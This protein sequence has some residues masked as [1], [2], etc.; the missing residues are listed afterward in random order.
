[1]ELSNLDYI[2]ENRQPL[3]LSRRR[4]TR[5]TS[6]DGHRHQAGAAFEAC[7]VAESV[8]QCDVVAVRLQLQSKVKFIEKD[9]YNNKTG[10]LKVM[11]AL[12]AKPEGKAEP[13]EW[14]ELEVVEKFDKFQVTLK[15]MALIKDKVAEY[16]VENL[17]ENAEADTTTIDS[18]AEQKK[19]L[20]K[21]LSTLRAVRDHDRSAA[22]NEKRKQ[23][24][25]TTKLIL[26][27]QKSELPSELSDWF[28]KVLLDG[29]TP[30][31][32]S[33][34]K[35]TDSDCFDETDDDLPADKLR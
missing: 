32:L 6:G 11:H 30:F 2:G 33:E 21:M 17:K 3:Q 14:T 18:V 20:E 31:D 8:D 15:A 9:V 24:T 28:L 26:P 4:L 27:F 22:C 19:G 7:L 34:I 25:Q 16:T 13:K 29:C 10:L 12:L 5:K 23:R 35:F 1:M